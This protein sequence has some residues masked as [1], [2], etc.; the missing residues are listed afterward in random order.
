[1]YIKREGDTMVT[2]NLSYNKEISDRDFLISIY[3]EIQNMKEVIQFIPN[4]ITIKD[5]AINNGLGYRQ[6]YRRVV[7]SG[8]YK[9]DKHFKKMDGEIYIH[10]SIIHSLQRK[11]RV[12]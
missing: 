3:E 11:R 7:E 9:M 8:N 4:W 1:M 12:A 10:K 6:M 5:V 2:N